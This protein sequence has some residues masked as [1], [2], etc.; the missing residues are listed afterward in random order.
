MVVLFVLTPQ[1][2][3][4]FKRRLKHRGNP[5]GESYAASYQTVLD[6][7]SMRR[8]KVHE[9]EMMDPFLCRGDDVSLAMDGA[10]GA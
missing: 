3:R 10:V 6:E 2:G 8:S 1:R 5:R 4:R 7:P 9:G